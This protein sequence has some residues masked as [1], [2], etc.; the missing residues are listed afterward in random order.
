M[1]PRRL[2]IAF[3]VVGAVGCDS[4]PPS[5][6]IPVHPAGGRVTFKGR[7]MAGALV[8][9][10]PSA[11]SSGSDEAGPGGAVRPT[12]RTDLE[13]NYKLHTYVGDDGAP[14]GDYRV[15]VAL[16]SASESRDLMS[17]DASR[18]IVVMLPPRFSDPARSGLGATIKAGENT[19]PPFDLK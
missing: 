5:G 4:P 9:F 7:P 2:P 17:K 10:H 18:T 12:G 14:A 6:P 19:V 11:A 1:L 13:G 3:L 8:V 15:T 16:G